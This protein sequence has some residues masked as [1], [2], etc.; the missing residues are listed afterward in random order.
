[1]YK[2]KKQRPSSLFVEEVHVNLDMFQIVFNKVKIIVGRSAN[3]LR[4]LQIRKFADLQNCYIC[5][6]SASVEIWGFAIRGLIKSN[7]RIWNV[8]SHHT[9]EIYGFAIVDWTQEFADL[10]FA[11]FKKQLRTHLLLICS[12]IQALTLENEYSCLVKKMY[13]RYIK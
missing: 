5:G 7:L 12:Y 10:R 8:R 3:K 2:M 4:E 9:S 6:P 13:K 1:M 11:D